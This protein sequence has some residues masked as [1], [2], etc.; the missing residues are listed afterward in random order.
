[1]AVFAVVV[2]ITRVENVVAARRARHH[3]LSVCAVPVPI[4]VTIIG[5]RDSIVCEPIAVVVFAIADFGRSH[6]AVAFIAFALGSSVDRRGIGYALR[7]IRWIDIRCV[8]LGAAIELG[9]AISIA[10]LWAALTT[11][12]RRVAA[13][14][15]NGRTNKTNPDEPKPHSAKLA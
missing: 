5:A 1:M 8:S 3:G 10:A 6:A 14:E 7:G 4:A 12:S 9:I 2:A 13:P 15:K 11:T